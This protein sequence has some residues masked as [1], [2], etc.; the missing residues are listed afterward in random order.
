MYNS[1]Y[2]FI[3]QRLE[4]TVLL[5]ALCSIVYKPVQFQQFNFAML[6]AYS[7]EKALLLLKLI[8]LIIIH[9]SFMPILPKELMPSPFNFSGISIYG[10]HRKRK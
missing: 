1:C 9:I 5:V 2:Y 6:S 8:I 3:I 10:M 4:Q 7:P